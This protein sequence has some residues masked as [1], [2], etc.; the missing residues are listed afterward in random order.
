[1]GAHAVSA[2]P[3]AW[4]TLAAWRLDAPD[5]RRAEAEALAAI[6]GRVVHG[7]CG[8][9]GA[10]T[11]FLRLPSAPGNLRE[12]LAC[13]RCGCNARQRAAAGVLLDAIGDRRARI[14]A[15]EHASALFVA[16]K[17][18]MPGLR[19]S[20]YA[21]GFLRRLRLSAWL[22]RHGVV[23][24][25]RHGD[26]TA[27][28]FADAALDA[29][30]CLDVLEHVPDCHAAL[31]EFARVLRPGGSLVLTVPFHENRAESARIAREREDGGIEH[32]GE[33][34]F[35]GDPLGGGVPCFH[36]FGWDLCDAARAA[37]F[38]DAAMRRVQDAAR[39]LPQGQWILH[40]RR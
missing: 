8:A 33:P 34:E 32:F 22:W 2:V 30:I 27:L 18:R 25:V 38:A 12:G 11:E 17:R 20:E 21:P 15:T 13:A 24:W 40:A 6:E 10:S 7:T 4:A 19:G 26:A 36:H 37:G 29:I 14:H 39:G 35:H 28:R 1:V 9:C 5:V 16:L 23:A 31:R 3:A